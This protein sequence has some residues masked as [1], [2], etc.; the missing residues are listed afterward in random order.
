[1]TPSPKKWSCPPKIFSAIFSKNVAFSEK[2]G[3][4]SKNR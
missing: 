1:M 3:E 2:I 4:F